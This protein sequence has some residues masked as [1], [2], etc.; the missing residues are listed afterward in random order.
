[1]DEPFGALDAITKATL[2]KT[3]LDLWQRR[4][5]SVVFITHD[6]TEAIALGDR[7]VVMSARPGRVREIVPIGLPRPRDIYTIHTDPAFRELYDR[8]WTHLADEMRVAA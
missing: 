4:Q 1:M 3:I 5:T 6:L 7:V 2:Q 8:I